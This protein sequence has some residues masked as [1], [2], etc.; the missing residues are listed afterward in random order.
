MKYEYVSR[1][2]YQPIRNELEEIIKKVQN[3]C[4]ELNKEFTFQFKLVGSGSRHL[5]TRVENGNTGYDF[6]YNLILNNHDQNS[7][8][9]P[10]YAK[11]LI[12][13]AFQKVLKGTNYNNPQDSTS[14][15]TIKVVDRKNKRIIHSCDFAIVYNVE[16]ADAEYY[17]Y[18]RFNK[19][20]NNYTWETRKCS[21]N[22]DRKLNWLKE[23]VNGYWELIKKEYLKVKNANNDKNKHSFQLYYESICNVYNWYKD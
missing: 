2:E 21:E 1:N 13:D 8:W 23:Y 4:R 12:M 10:S 22:I 14:A 5:I 15:I 6:D 17:K 3:I 19:A 9:Q 16:D 18:I 20:Q 11:R 7:H